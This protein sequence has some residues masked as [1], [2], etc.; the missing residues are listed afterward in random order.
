MKFEIKLCMKLL[1]C[2]INNDVKQAIIICDK[3]S[4][5]IDTYKNA[6]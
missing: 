4:K 2:L 1:K 6:C 3:L 5:V